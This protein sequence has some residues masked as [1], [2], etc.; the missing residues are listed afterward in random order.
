MLF[1]PRGPGA[2]VAAAQ[3]LFAFP[4]PSSGGFEVT[5][6]HRETKGKR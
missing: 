6:A 4:S 1:A 5:L 2:G 3:G